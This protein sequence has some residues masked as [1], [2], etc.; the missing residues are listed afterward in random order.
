MHGLFKLKVWVLSVFFVIITFVAPVQ[1]TANASQ[2]NQMI[3]NEYLQNPVNDQ[4]ESPTQ[5]IDDENTQLAGGQGLGAWDYIK[6][7]LSLIFVLA[8]LLFV[9]KF[10][11]KK[12]SNYQQNNNVRNLGG[13][14]LGSQK[15]V[16]LLQIGQS[17]YIVGVGENIQLIKEL[18]NQDE[19]EQL[20]NNFNDRQTFVATT[21]YIA[22][23][24]KKLKLNKNQQA[25]EQSQSSFGELFNNQLSDIKKERRDELEKWME[26]EHDK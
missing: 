18:S 12:S 16:Q 2:N 11:N 19:I 22:E 3:T 26:K 14:T 23:L 9:L 13:I 15:S 8:L 4:D 5:T 20:I 6:M 7:L 21:P 24:F 1:L 25:S 10:I 17:I